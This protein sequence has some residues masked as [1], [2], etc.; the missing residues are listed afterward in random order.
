MTT[1][2]QCKIEISRIIHKKWLM[3]DNLKIH[4]DIFVTPINN[5]EGIFFHEDMVVERFDSLL[6]MFCFFFKSLS[7]NWTHMSMLSK[8]FE[9]SFFGWISIVF[10]QMSKWSSGSK[11]ITS[12]CLLRNNEIDNSTIFTYPIE[13]FES[14][15]RIRKMLKYMARYKKILAICWNSHEIVSGANI[16]DIH[17]LEP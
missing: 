9:I 6:E 14:S 2:N 13:F 4:W 10:D 17:Q 11:S 1:D 7:I 5:I 3:I 12:S 16:F 15:N 8:M